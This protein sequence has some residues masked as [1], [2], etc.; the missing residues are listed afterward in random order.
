MEVNPNG[1]IPALLDNRQGKKPI[2]VWESAS[3]LLYLAK[4]YDTKFDFYF[5]EEDMQTEILN[6]I[7]FM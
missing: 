5:Q 7:F 1:R 2:A 3:I 4:T 6:W